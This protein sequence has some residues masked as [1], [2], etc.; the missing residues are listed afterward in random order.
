MPTIS[1][2][3]VAFTWMGNY[4]SSGIYNK[5][6]VVAYQGNSYVCLQNGTTGV[7]PGDNAQWQ[8]FAQGVSALNLEAGQ[9]LY[10]N[11]A[12]LTGLPNGTTGQILTVG[13]DGSPAW[14]TPVVRSGTKVAKL[15]ENSRNTQPFSYRM[16][17]A[18]M[19]DGSVR[20]WG[21]DGN[22]KMGQGNYAPTRSYPTRTAFPMGFPGAD[23]LYLPYNTTSHCIDV[24]GDL[25]IW[26]YNGQGQWGNGGTSQ[27]NNVPYN[28]STNVN[29]SIYDKT[30]TNLA[31]LCGNQDSPT[32]MVLTSDGKVHSTG[33]NAYGQLG[34]GDTTQRNNFNEVPILSNIL[35]I[36]GGR[37]AY[38]TFYAVKNDGTLYGWGYNGD[39]N[40]GNGGTTNGTIPMPIANGSL[41]GK[42]VIRAFGSY[43]G[44]FALCDDGTL[45]AWGNATTYGHLGTASFAIQTT[46]KQVAED[47]EDVYAGC[48]D[49]PRA[50][51]KKTNGTLW[52]AGAGNY[53]ARGTNSTSHIAIF[54]PVPLRTTVNKCVFGGTGSYNYGAALLTD[55]TVQSFGYNGNGAL[56]NGS[57]TQLNLPTDMLTGNHFITDISCFG[58]SS[59]Q[60]FC[61]LT[62]TGDLLVTGYAGGSQLPEDDSENSYVPMPVVF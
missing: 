50:F 18:I 12:G 30:V 20:V 51:I 46:P 38:A 62:A 55:G 35:S 49:Y 8:L 19:Q 36:A 4:S 34:M 21:S 42:T 6:D 37:E 56:G 24:D 10:H 44:A 61:L 29:N 33:Y 25:W 47:V 31:Q 3:K 17:G 59:E 27:G 1:L 60:S 39:Y 45:H 52:A 11:G 28:A 22:F 23:K 57:T 14:T 43:L 2:G 16:F 53:S 40:L 5:Q 41:A 58:N 32:S 7:A 26:G 9:I 54:E 15:P 13:E 48:Y